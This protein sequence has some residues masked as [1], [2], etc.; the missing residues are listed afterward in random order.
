MIKVAKRY[1]IFVI[2]FVLAAFFSL[3]V[4]A[5]ETAVADDVGTEAQIVSEELEGFRGSISPEV[6]DLL[7]EG[8]FSADVTEMGEAV[9]QASDLGAILSVIGEMLGLSVGK[10]LAMLARICGLLLIGAIFRMLARGQESGAALEGAV[11]FCG[12]AALA[13]GIFSLQRDTFAEL[14]LYFE[15]LQTLAASLIPL[16]GGL[17][18]MGGNVGAAVANHGVMSSF[19]AVL[20]TVVSGSVLPVAGLCLVLAL[21]DALSGSGRLRSLAGLIKRSYTLFFSFLMLILCGVLGIQT[22]LAGGS[23]TLA[24]RTVRFAAGSFLPVVGGSVS[25]ALR[26]VSG[27]VQYLRTVVGMGGVVVVLLFFLPFF[28]NVMLGRIA[29][30]LSSAAAKLLGCDGEERLLNE[31]ASVYGYFMAVIASL[32]VMIVFSLTLFARCAAAGGGV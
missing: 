17:Y 19:L 10:H 18:A 15:G 29:F 4:L 20:E 25:E 28:L 11:S 31:L 16:M 23:D 2:L 6:A 3:P 30:L 13:V 22:T 8:F 24:L 1:L 32:F 5:V 27:S 9:R 26:T 21:S 7:P 14:S 12:T